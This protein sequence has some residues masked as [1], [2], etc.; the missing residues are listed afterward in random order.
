MLLA[1]MSSQTVVVPFLLALFIQLYN[2]SKQHCSIQ[3]CKSEKR[4][5]N[6]FTGIVKEFHIVPRTA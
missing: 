2:K 6:A 3:P 5:R 4:G 1:L